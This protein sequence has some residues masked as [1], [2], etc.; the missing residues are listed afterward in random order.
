MLHN[1]L[2]F[3]GSVLGF[4]FSLKFAAGVA[5]GVLAHVSIEHLVSSIESKVLH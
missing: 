5:V 3:L 1:L 4:V 2:A